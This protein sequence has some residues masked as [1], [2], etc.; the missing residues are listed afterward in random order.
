M[1]K[2]KIVQDSSLPTGERLLTFSVM[3]GRLIHS[4]LLRHRAASHSVKSSRAIPTHKYRAEVME[5]IYVPVKFGTKKKGMQAGEPTF[6]T[7]FYGEKIWK[8]SSKFA[9]FFHWMMEKFGIHKEVANRV[10]EPYVWVEETITVEADALKEIAN[11]RVHDDAQE[12]VRRIVEEMVYEMDRSTPV[13]LNQGQWHVPYVVRRQVENEMIYTDNTGNKLTLDQAIICSAAR[14]ARSSYANH[15]NSMSSYDKD[16]GLAKQLVGSEPMHL[17][18]F[19]HQ[20]R[21]FTDDT[22]KSQYSSN[23]R[24]FFQQRKAIENSLWHV[25]INS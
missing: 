3:Y 21:P 24:N 8:L 25:E 9:C 12:D 17:S 11:L 2:A 1:I 18:P 16:I 4:E 14:C 22:E 20:A 7:K 6:L 23:F 15:D 10:L 19:E 5:N 13:E